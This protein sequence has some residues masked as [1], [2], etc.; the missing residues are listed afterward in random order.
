MTLKNPKKLFLSIFAVLYIISAA[1]P[2]KVSAFSSTCKAGVFLGWD[3]NI[4]TS[5]AYTDGYSNR[6]DI[7]SYDLCNW[8]GN[9]DSSSISWDSASTIRDL[10]KPNIPLIKQYKGPYAHLIK[11]VIISAHMPCPTGGTSNGSISPQDFA[12]LANTKIQDINSSSPWFLQ[13]YK[14]IVSKVGDGLEYYGHVGT[15]YFR[16]FHEVNGNWFWWGDKD[17]SQYKQ[18]WINLHDYLVSKNSGCRGLTWLKFCYAPNSGKNAA[19]YYPGDDYVDMVGMDAYSDNPSTDTYVKRAYAELTGGTYNGVTYPGIDK[20]FGFPELGPNVGGDYVDNKNRL[21]KK[22]D[23]K[24]WSDAIKLN[25][26]KASYFIIWNG[27]Y[28]PRNNDNGT[29]LFNMSY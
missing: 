17:V 26:P 9:N 6:L 16:P 23:Y 20:P 8:N 18:L 12:T 21:I 1:N 29:S 2:T 7:I 4:D 13:N 5:I 3:R 28:E 19:L 10:Q 14:A 22:F 25:Y 15:V 11:N 24:R 27:G